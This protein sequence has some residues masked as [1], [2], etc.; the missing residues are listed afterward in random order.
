LYEAVEMAGDGR[1]TD[2]IT[3]VALFRLGKFLDRHGE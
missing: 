2:A 3:I 1:I